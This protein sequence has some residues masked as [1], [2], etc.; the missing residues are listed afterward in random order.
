MDRRRLIKLVIIATFGVLIIVEGFTLLS[1]IGVHLGGGPSTASPGTD[2]GGATADPAERVGPGDELLADTDRRETVQT[3]F[4]AESDENRT[5]TMTITVENAGDAGYELEV[6]PLTT[7]DGTTV[8]GSATTGQIEAGETATVSVEWSLP[9]GSSPDT[10]AVTAFQHR[11]D[12]TQI[13]V[14][15]EVALADPSGSG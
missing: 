2:T 10:V 8:S 1:L 4:I 6:G 13:L 5:L 14:S 11:S 15:R 7:A 12:S 9:A 3:L